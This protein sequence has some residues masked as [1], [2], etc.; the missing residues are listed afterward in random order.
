MNQSSSG[1]LFLLSVSV[2]V[3]M[4]GLG[5]IWPLIPVYA[6]ELGAGGFLLGLIIA[7]FNVSRTLFSPFAGQISDKLGRKKFIVLGLFVYAIISVFYVLP[8]NARTLIVIRFFHGLASVLVVPIAMALAA[9]IAPKQK[10]GL[11]MG[12]LNMSVMIGLGIGPALGGIIRDNFGMNSTFYAMGVLALL[13]CILVMI[14]LPPDS[15][16]H[17]YKKDKKPYSIKKMLTHPIVLGIFLMRFFA[18]SGQGAVYTFL[19]ILALQL[20]LTSSQVGIILTANI[21]LIAFLQRSCG[22]LADRI[23]PKYLVIIGTFASGLTVFGMPFVEGFMMILLLNIL[24]GMSN[25]ISLPGGLVI[26]G[27]LGRTM[28][29]A[30]LMSIT[31][32]AWSLGMIVSPIL[33]GIILDV[34]GLSYVFIIGSLLIVTGGIVVTFFLWNYKPEQSF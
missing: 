23:N 34:F 32:A 29:M 15:Q 9:D 19:P 10:L 11:Y 25:G 33:S 17:G 30:S 4:T 26:T 6:V 14:F 1:I 3:A 20:K 31:D 8:E 22:R 12:T 16:G 5:I 18:A 28:G 2:G 24:M 13:T 7:S 21:F 27:Q